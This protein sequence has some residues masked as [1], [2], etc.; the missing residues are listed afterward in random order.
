MATSYQ[1]HQV[2]TS[3]SLALADLWPSSTG[4]YTLRIEL[5]EVTAACS[6]EL[7][8]S[9]GPSPLSARLVASAE[10]PMLVGPLPALSLHSLLPLRQGRTQ[11]KSAMTRTKDTEEI[12]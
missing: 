10:T 3:W 12:L 8:L 6:V 9:S 5:T 2:H 1:P 11:Q 4:P 7:W